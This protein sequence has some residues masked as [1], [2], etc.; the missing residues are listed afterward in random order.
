MSVLY[1]VLE[2]ICAIQVESVL[3]VLII[4]FLETDTVRKKQFRNVSLLGKCK[5]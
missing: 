3:Q 1:F 2:N 4:D 5:V